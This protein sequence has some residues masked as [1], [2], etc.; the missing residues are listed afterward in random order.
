MKLA[1]PIFN[2]L[3]TNIN[4]HRAANSPN[5][6]FNNS[7]F[8]LFNLSPQQTLHRIML[9]LCNNKLFAAYAV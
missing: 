3:Y 2:D 7:F 4:V 8:R 1:I 6:K 9:P 5:A